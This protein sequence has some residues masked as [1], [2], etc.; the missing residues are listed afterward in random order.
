MVPCKASALSMAMAAVFIRLA[1]ATGIY[2]GGSNECI[3]HL[4]AQLVNV[5]AQQTPSVIFRRGGDNGLPCLTGQANPAGEGVVHE[6]LSSNGVLRMSGSAS[7]ATQLRERWD[8]LD[9]LDSLRD[10]RRF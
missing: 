4:R 8:S 5:L 7:G 9:S 6:S 1:R 2:L 3:D 10:T